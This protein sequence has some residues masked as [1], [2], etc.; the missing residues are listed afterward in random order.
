MVIRMFAQA[1]FHRPSGWSI[2]HR[3]H[4]WL[5]Q[6]NCHQMTIMGQ[7]ISPSFPS[8]T[9]TQRSLY[10]PATCTPLGAW[11]LFSEVPC[12]QDLLNKLYLPDLVLTSVLISMTLNSRTWQLRSSPTLTSSSFKLLLYGKQY[13]FIPWSSQ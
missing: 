4:L 10:K 13:A 12:V 3:K 8:S 9:P 7:L 5:P 6:I 11:L 2:D 1:L